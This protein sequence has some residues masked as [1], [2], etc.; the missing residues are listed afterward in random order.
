MSAMCTPRGKGRALLRPVTPMGV[1]LPEDTPSKIRARNALECAG[2]R[3]RQQEE[4]VKAE[5]D[6]GLDLHQQMKE[7]RARRAGN[8]KADAALRRDLAARQ[9]AHRNG[10]REQEAERERMEKAREQDERRATDALKELRRLELE[11]EKREIRQSRVERVLHSKETKS[12]EEA[13]ERS[14]V[15]KEYQEGLA[16]RRRKEELEKAAKKADVEARKAAILEARDLKIKE[17]ALAASVLRAEIEHAREVAKANEAA[18]KRTA[19]E[20]RQALRAR[21]D[22]YRKDKELAKTSAFSR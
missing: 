7:D 20:H 14:T 4:V 9:T 18:N 10:I 13:L 17:R 6:T 5:L 15:K 22:Q 12:S 16:E 19:E 21:A 1:D 3:R 8:A 11:A 2:I